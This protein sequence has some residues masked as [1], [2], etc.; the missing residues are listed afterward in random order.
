MYTSLKILILSIFLRRS[1]HH[2]WDFSRL[3]CCCPNYNVSKSNEL[4]ASKECRIK[5]LYQKKV[6]RNSNIYC[7]PTNDALQKPIPQSTLS[8]EEFLFSLRRTLLK[9]FLS[10]LPYYLFFTLFFLRSVS[11]TLDPQWNFLPSF[12]LIFSWWKELGKVLVLL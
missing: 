8:G 4:S 7:R 2:H 9:R 6:K 5:P 10:N 11:L 12:N 3:L 1:N